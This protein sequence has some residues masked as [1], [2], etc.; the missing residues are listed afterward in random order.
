MALSLRGFYRGAKKIELVGKN[1]D[2]KT[3]LFYI[4]QESTS[5]FINHAEFKLLHDNV[6]KVDNLKDGQE[7]EVF[8]RVNGRK[9]KGT[10]DG[11]EK[12]YFFQDLNAYRIDE[13]VRRTAGVPEVNPEDVAVPGSDD[14]GLPF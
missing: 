2:I 10:K 8:F 4:E 5:G 12:E 1:G 11:V 9:A 13:V 14:D 6:V 7:I 3:R